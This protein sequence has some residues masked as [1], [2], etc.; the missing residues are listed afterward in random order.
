MQ[1]NRGNKSFGSL[2]DNFSD[3]KYPR[4]ISE[5]PKNEEELLAKFG[6]F[7]P[8]FKTIA[9]AE[10]GKAERAFQ[11]TIEECK[12]FERAEWYKSTDGVNVYAIKNPFVAL[13]NEKTGAVIRITPKHLG[14]LHQAKAKKDN[15]GTSYHDLDE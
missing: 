14:S 2:L 11:R 3:F 4:K 15:F 9:P 6:H 10:R 12:G 13:V 7:K 5:A 1:D 8:D